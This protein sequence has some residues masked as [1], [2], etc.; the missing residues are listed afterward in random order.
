MEL[1]LT[2]GSIVWRNLLAK[3][4]LVYSEQTCYVCQLPVCRESN[5][6]VL[7]SLVDIVTNSRAV[8]STDVC[9]TIDEV[10]YATT[11]VLTCS[12]IS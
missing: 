6:R 7:W 9:S 3:K 2:G 12:L 8:V 1:N 11:T 4:Q 5:A 10:N